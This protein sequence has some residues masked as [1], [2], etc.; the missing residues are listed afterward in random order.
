M[1]G[2]IFDMQKVSKKFPGVQALDKVDFNCRHG[3][4]HALVGENGAGK[5]TLMK[6]LAGAY[7]QDEGKIILKGEEV[8]FSGPREAQEND[9]SSPLRIIFVLRSQRSAGKRH[10]DHI[11]GVQFGT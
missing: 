1:N 10:H 6:I 5:S 4:V 7:R 8:S 3:E 11:S 2:N 9:T